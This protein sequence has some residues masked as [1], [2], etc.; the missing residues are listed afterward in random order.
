MEKLIYPVW[1]PDGLGQDIFRD[2]LLQNTG[3]ALPY[4]QPLL[5]TESLGSLQ[6]YDLAHAVY[7]LT[8]AIWV[9][10]IHNGR[11]LCHQIGCK[12]LHRESDCVLNGSP[13]PTIIDP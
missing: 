12:S 10:G 9:Q 6:E 4:F 13:G 3:T 1:G 7:P 11:G 5:F 8:R 2:Q